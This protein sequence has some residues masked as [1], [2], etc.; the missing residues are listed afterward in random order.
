MN[1][2]LMLL[3]L[4]ALALSACRGLGVFETPTPAAAVRVA[5]LP[6]AL[7]TALP[8]SVVIEADAEEV[9]LTNLYERVNPSIVN[10]EIAAQVTG[11]LTELGSGSGFIIDTDGH[12]VTNN[13][14][15]ENA[16]RIYVTFSDSSV[17]E[18]KLVGR[19]LYSD[20]AV[21]RVSGAE[22]ALLR[23]VEL[24]DSDQVKV[25]QR[26]VAI[27][28]PFGLVGTMTVGVVS[29]KGRTLPADSL[30][31]DAGIFSN[32]DIIQTD[33]PIN[34]GNSG[35]PLLDS[36]GRVIGVNSAIR[37]TGEN[38]ANSGV[39][40]AVPVNTVKRIVPQLIANGRAAYPY[41]GVSS[42]NR[43]T[44]PEL[45]LALDLPVKRGVLISGV[46][47]GGPADQ[48]GLRGG[49]R[50]EVVRGSEVITGGDVIT[51]ID[52]MPITS[53]DQMIAYLILHTEVGQTVKLTF[54]RGSET[55][56]VDL[57]LGERPR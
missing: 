50:R 9:L 28:N 18:A 11:D 25:G 31:A 56:E 48:A 29:G 52:G 45:A 54:V 5:P 21:I 43:F 3:T 19:D 34:P 53:F 49:S 15:V 12:I 46:V 1:N 32:P 6:T 35:G 20:L 42:E 13:H 37:T 23:P 14:V 38:R 7:P 30:S 44:L 4:A 17:A 16:D 36:H 2:R 39:G 57:R 8:E 33:A 27:G 22:P 40:F 26:V 55:L 41:L 10:I 24:G 51:A 47:D